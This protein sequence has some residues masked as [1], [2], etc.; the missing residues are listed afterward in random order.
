MNIAVGLSGGVDSAVAALLLQRAGHRV[1]GVTMKLWPDDTPLRGGPR[2]ACFG[3][4]EA[5]D[6]AAAEALAARLDIP[7][8]MVDGRRITDPQM[9]DVVTMVYGGLVNKRLVCGL[10]ALGVDAVGLSGADGGLIRSHRRPPVD[11]VDYGS[12]YYIQI[13]YNKSEKFFNLFLFVHPPVPATF[14]IPGGPD[15]SVSF[16]AQ[17]FD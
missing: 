16:A 12:T 17:F 13:N 8:R 9:L 4:G 10:Q 6:I 7:T 5:A 1:T 14:I 2:D 3:P 11:G 15:E